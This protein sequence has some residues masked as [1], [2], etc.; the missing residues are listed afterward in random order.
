MCF[1]W[2]RILQ[3][4]LRPQDTTYADIFNWLS[5]C[6]IRSKFWVLLCWIYFLQAKFLKACGTLAETPIEFRKV[7][8]KCADVSTHREE[9]S[10]F[11]SWIPSS[12]IDKLNFEKQPDESS[13][14]FKVSGEWVT[15]AGF[16]VGTPS[17]YVLCYMA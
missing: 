13:T 11:N 12:S 2:Y 6:L 7:S 10:K 5:Q 15:G 8:A 3:S 4:N 17:R 14:P 9:L 1:V 16:L